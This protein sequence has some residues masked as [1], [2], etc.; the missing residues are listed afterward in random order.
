MS[1]KPNPY[2]LEEICKVK[3]ERKNRAARVVQEKQRIL[4]AEEQKLQQLQAEYQ[5]QIDYKTNRINDLM[6]MRDR[7][8]ITPSYYKQMML[9]T[10]VLD[11]KIMTAYK[12]IEQQRVVIQK[13][14][15][16]VNDAK[17]ELKLREIEVDKI[18]EHKKEWVEE[19]KKRVD[20]IIEDELD[21]IGALMI[22][23][24]KIQDKITFGEDK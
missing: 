10:I 14:Q 19:E 20:E 18:K 15:K 9:F 12:Y 4:D 7:G 13:A 5:Q 6:D 2:P 21:E 24:K 22:E 8:E 11:E 1:E 3:E 16:A 17:A 23:S